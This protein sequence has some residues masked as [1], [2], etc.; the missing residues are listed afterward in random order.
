[1]SYSYGHVVHCNMSHVLDL[2]SIL[3]LGGRRV[4][5]L[6]HSSFSILF[7]WHVPVKLSTT[8]SIQEENKK[9]DRK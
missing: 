8:I 4:P 2:T 7:A 9:G 1:M 6:G 5:T 3:I